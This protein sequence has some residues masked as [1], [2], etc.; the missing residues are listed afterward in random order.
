MCEFPRHYSLSSLWKG[1]GAAIEDLGVFIFLGRSNMT[2]RIGV[3]ANA[4]MMT[5][6]DVTAQGQTGGITRVLMGWVNSNRAY[7]YDDWVGAILAAG[8]GGG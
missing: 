3:G 5:A 1:A 8:G 2:L 6:A 7:A 4:A